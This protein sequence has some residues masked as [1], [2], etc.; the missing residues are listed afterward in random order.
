M[1]DTNTNQPTPLPEY[2]LP[3]TGI[4][5]YVPK[6]WVPYGE[7]MRIDKPTGIYAFY[8][9]HLFGTL[10]ACILLQSPPNLHLLKINTI[11]FLGCIFM[12]G[13]ACSWNDTLDCEYDRQ[14]LRCRLRPIA[15]RAL[16]TTQGHI[17]TA[18]LAVVAL[19]FLV[20]LPTDCWI[21]AIPKICLLALYPFAKRFTDFPQLVLGFEMSSGLFIG[22]AAMGYNFRNIQ[23]HDSITLGLFYAA[24]ICWTVIYDTV[25][26]QQDVE[27]DAKA[28][29]R[30]MAVRFKDGPRTLL[31]WV[32]I[33]KVVLL[34]T[35]GWVQ[36]W[37]ISY[38]SITC[39]GTAALLFWNVYTLDLK[40]PAECMWWFV[41]GSRMVGATMSAGLALES[42]FNSY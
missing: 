2:K 12:R 13:A 22:V 20:Q 36:E 31:A 29:V 6:S 28:G 32:A 10:L 25:Y 18:F 14:V 41:Y 15:R 21:L 30:S 16:S 11:L 23:L 4:L 37:G 42:F 35:I 26:A 3:T 17:F 27:D 9:H 24:Q 33:V 8:F 38:Y 40:S 34:V 7:L 5:S 39:A 19:A 1:L